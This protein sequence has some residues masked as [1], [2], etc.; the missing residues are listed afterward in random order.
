[1]GIFPNH[2]PDPTVEDN[3]IDLIK[4]MKTGNYDVGIA[5]DGRWR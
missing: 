1:M 2:H 4:Y 5:F 3:L